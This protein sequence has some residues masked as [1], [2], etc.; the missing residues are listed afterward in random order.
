[1]FLIS[2]QAIA[3]IITLGIKVNLLVVIPTQF[4]ILST[5]AKMAEVQSL[6]F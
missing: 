5:V 6:Y 2:L 1:M 3:R 4:S